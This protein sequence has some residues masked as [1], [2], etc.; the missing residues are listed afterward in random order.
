MNRD[1]FR[2]KNLHKNEKAEGICIGRTGIYFSCVHKY[3]EIV[4]D[5]VGKINWGQIWQALKGV[6]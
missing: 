1:P 5:K 2:R 4:G 6:C 3:E